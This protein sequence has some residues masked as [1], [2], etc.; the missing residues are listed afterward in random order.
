MCSEFLS[1]GDALLFVFGS[2][3]FPLNKLNFVHMNLEF[4]ARV[5]A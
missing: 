3:T 1:D 2:Q 5:N 4:D